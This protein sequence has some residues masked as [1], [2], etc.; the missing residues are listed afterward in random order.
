MDPVTEQAE[1][2]R[3]MDE[4]GFSEEEARYVLAHQYG[5][6]RGDIKTQPPMT[7]EEWSRRG[8]GVL[9]EPGK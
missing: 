7:E 9:A 3:L 1:I 2:Q 6:N 8:L 5:P 4:A